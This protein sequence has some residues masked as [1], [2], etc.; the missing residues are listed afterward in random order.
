MYLLDHDG[1]ELN[2]ITHPTDQCWYNMVKYRNELIHCIELVNTK[3]KSRFVG[4]DMELN[5]KWCCDVTG[6]LCK[7]GRVFDELSGRVYADN[8]LDQIV[9]FD[10]ARREITAVLE[11]SPHERYTLE[12]VLP[13]AGPVLYEISSRCIA[14]ANENMEII[15]RHKLKPWDYCFYIPRDEQ[16]FLLACKEGRDQE[17]PG[18]TYIYELKS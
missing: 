7:F 15:S 18:R 13:G 5:E 1:T 10:I 9:S 17:K 3:R 2:R 11:P 16:L 4:Y 14:V 8:G 6:Y 12:A